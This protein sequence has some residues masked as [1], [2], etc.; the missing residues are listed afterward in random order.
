VILNDTFHPQCRSS[1]RSANTFL[2]IAHMFKLAQ[3]SGII[4]HVS[5]R[6]ATVVTLVALASGCSRDHSLTDPG[7]AA[8]KSMTISFA[9][10][11]VAPVISAQNNTPFQAQGDVLTPAGHAARSIQAVNGK[12]T[13]IITRAQLVLS[14]VELTQTAGTP[15]DDDSS[16]SGCT[17]IERHFVLVDLPTDTSVHTVLNANIPDGTYASLEARLR[18]PRSSDDSDATAFLSAH[19]ELAGAN[20]RVE[21]TFDGQPFTYL[22]AVDT[23][24]E[25]TFTPPIAVTGGGVNVTVLVDATT[26]FRDGTGALVDPSSANAGGSNA[27]RVS[28]NIRRSFRAVRDDERDGHDHG[29]EDDSHRG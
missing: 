7:A 1:S 16:A 26:W 23:R 11:T 3:Y 21:G 12:D 29:G 25:L 4:P 24:F 27:S 5:T 28:D 18:I 22:G 13:L 6:T 9:T 15:C 14:R 10:R 2:E 20:V 19:P 8:S 17:E